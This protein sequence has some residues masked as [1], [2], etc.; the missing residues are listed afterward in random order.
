MEYLAS[1][2]RARVAEVKRDAQMGVSLAERDA[3]IQEAQC[4]KESMDIRY[5]TNANTE[6]Q[7]RNFQMQK[8][9]FDTEVCRT[10]I[11]CAVF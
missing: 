1:L 2:G 5:S 9:H 11:T 7:K 3:G 4:K 6:E 10:N 8:S